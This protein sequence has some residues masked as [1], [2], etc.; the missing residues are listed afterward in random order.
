MGHRRDAVRFL[1]GEFDNPAERRIGP[2]QGDIRAMEGRDRLEPPGIE[3]LLGQ[4]GAGRVGNRI[5]G[6]DDVEMVDL[7]QLDQFG[8]QAQL[9]GGGLEQG[10]G[11]DLD[12]VDEDILMERP[13]TERR[14]V[15]DDMDLVAFLAR[16]M[17]NSEATTPLPPWVG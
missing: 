7:R 5:M 6:V 13:Q 16:P 11:R 17:A 1:D 10:I 9:V 2:D 3:D 15:A 14:R 4:I 12:F 8:G